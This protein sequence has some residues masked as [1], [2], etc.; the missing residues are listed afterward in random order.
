VLLGASVLLCAGSQLILK[1]A[2]VD[3]GGVPTL[4]RL[5]AYLPGL[6]RFPVIAGLGLYAMGTTLWLGCLTRLE[7]SVAYPASA[8]QSLWV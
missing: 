3:V 4:D 8:V 7:L 2:M 5:I 6:F 1:Q